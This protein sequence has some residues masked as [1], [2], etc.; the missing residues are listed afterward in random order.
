MT[1]KFIVEIVVV[2]YLFISNYT[3]I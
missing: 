1:A 2:T 3:M